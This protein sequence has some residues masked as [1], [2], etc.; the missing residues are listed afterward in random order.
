MY[1][2][3]TTLG[4]SAFDAT[5]FLASN[6][7]E[8]NDATEASEKVAIA[9]VHVACLHLTCEQDAICEALLRYTSSTLFE[10]AVRMYTGEQYTRWLSDPAV[11]QMLQGPTP[12]NAEVP[13]TLLRAGFQTPHSALLDARVRVHSCIAVCACV[14]VCLCVHMP[15]GPVHARIENEGCIK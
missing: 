2:V 3:N 4:V 6:N 7:V 8:V 14:D 9:S 12:V 1:S 11:V 5:H 15:A 10:R 13:L